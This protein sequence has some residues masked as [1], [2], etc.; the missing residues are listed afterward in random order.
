[1]IE[2]TAVAVVGAGITGLAL[3]YHLRSF[4]IS[5]VVLEA[6]DRVG[7]VIRS[8]RIG[9]HLLDWG[10]QR[11]RLTA[12]VQDILTGLDLSHEVVSAPSDLPLYVYRSGK[13]RRV[14]FSAP[15]FL[16]SDIAPFR[17][18]LRILLEPLTPGARPEET[19]ADYFTR[20]LGRDLYENLA[21]PLYGGLYA[22]D[23]ADMTVE[24]S[25]GHALREFRVGRSL[26]LAFLRR[27]GRASPPP[28]G[29]FR[30]GMETLPRALHAADDANVRLDAPVMDLRRE[31]GRWA[32]DWAGG[33]ILA[34]AVVL[35]TP[36]VA[37]ERLLRRECPAAAD[38]IARL[39]YNPLA[40]VH[41][42]ANTSLRALGF[43][44]SLHERLATRGVTFNDSI[45]DREGVYTAYLGGAKAPEVVQWS[46][47]EIGAVAV[48]EF[49]SI[50]GA[51]ARVISVARE[52]MPAWDSSW[53]A[54]R[55]LQLP[56]GIHVA[57][58]WL[59]RPGIV[60]RL[61]QAKQLADRWRREGA[62]EAAA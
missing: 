4:G 35:T 55:D 27:G 14:P 42:H 19:V 48:R 15:A 57:A 31:A 62:G 46:D 40:I 53:G 34:A 38:R 26:V 12:G 21:G 58:N 54:I 39:R 25:L 1:M 52:S 50:T 16:L 8:A 43:Q 60:G 24:L 47:G 28:I 49:H 13:L 5:H 22:S 3:G 29:G 44:V 56:A 7:G 41:L 9:D 23:P 2:R 33:T 59:S 11:L 30:E 18:R 10:P 45:F 6:S 51:E 36:A 37:T 61:S 17:A 20:K 32:V